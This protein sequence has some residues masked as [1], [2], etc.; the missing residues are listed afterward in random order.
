MAG[1]TNG[2]IRVLDAATGQII[3]WI[4]LDVQIASASLGQSVFYAP[5]AEEAY[6]TLAD[7][8]VLRFNTATNGVDVRLGPFEGDPIGAVGYDV[9]GERLYLGRFAGYAT[10]ADVTVHDRDG[11]EIGRFPAGIAP[12]FVDFRVSIDE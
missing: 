2:A 6:A 12:T 5:A 9:R 7:T 4:D 8:T 1:T 3:E 10:P 11:A